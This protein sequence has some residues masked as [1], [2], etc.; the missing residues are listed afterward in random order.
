VIKMAEF[1]TV[2]GM[3]D[4]P[5]EKTGKWLFLR[6]T[7]TH[8]FRKYGFEPLQT[9]MVEYFK[10]LAMK[11]AGGDVIKDDI[12]YFKDKSGR[13]LGL[14][15]DLTIPLARFV[16]KNKDL[17]KPFKRYTIDRVYRYDRPGQNR[18]REF[19]QADVDIVGSA[20]AYADF[21]ILAITIEVMKKLGLKFFIKINNQKL[22][23]EIAIRCGVGKN[24]AGQC[25][26]CL[27]KLDKI[28]IE[29]VKN[30]LKKNKIPAKVVNVLKNKDL[31]DIEKM[32]Q[33]KTGLQELDQLLQLL[34]KENLDK[35][36]KVDLCLARGLD[37]YT[38]NVFEVMAKGAESS[39]A[40]GGRYDKLIGLFG[41]QEN[42][43]V[44]ISFGIDRLLD[45]LEKKIPVE[46]CPKVFVAAVGKEMQQPALELT[47]KIRQLGISASMDLNARGISKNLDYVNKVGI[48]FVAIIGEKECKEKCF[49]L[50]EM[51]SGKEK[52]IKISDLKQLKDRL[53]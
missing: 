44:G 18:Y 53:K 32:L 30:E 20:S 3:R 6:D 41:G 24:N 40:G 46:A 29:G 35:Y 19:M 27:D 34:K 5:P 17:P 38:G 43:A 39:V 8:V 13:E 51:A 22:L 36:T 37:Y 16:A 31:Q 45:L 47:Q 42:P 2:R 25:L 12:Y 10:A 1:Q 50:K 21:E 7:F 28:G 48:P 26:R 23:E 49:T 9:P 33:D 4:L 52:K 15:F 11:G 14:R